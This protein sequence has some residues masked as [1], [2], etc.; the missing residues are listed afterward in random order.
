MI[1]YLNATS[2]MNNWM[3]RIAVH[4]TETKD[5]VQLK[6]EHPTLAGTAQGG[7]MEVRCDSFGDWRP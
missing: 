1:S 6:F 3:F 2:M 4:K 7:W 5:G